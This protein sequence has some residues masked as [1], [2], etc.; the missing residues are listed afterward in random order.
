MYLLRGQEHVD[1]HGVL[2]TQ[3]LTAT[4][5]TFR[6]IVGDK[7]SA[8]FN[9]RI[10][11]HPDAQKTWAELSNKNLLTS[12]GGSKYQTRQIYA[13]D[14]GVRTVLPWRSWMVCCT[15]CEPGES[16]DEALVLLSYGFIN[17]LV[18]SKGLSHCDYLKPR[19]A[20]YFGVSAVDSDDVGLCGRSVSARAACYQINL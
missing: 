3:C 7:A 1:Y 2:N 8:V 14:V 17:A 4:D 12:N 16:A 13:D 15:I 18:K 20:D 5:E 6:G 19:L 11:I 10:H 9:G